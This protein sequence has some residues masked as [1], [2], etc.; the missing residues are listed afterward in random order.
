MLRKPVITLTLLVL[1]SLVVANS[2]IPHD[3]VAAWA[4]E[5]LTS[6]TAES[7]EI[8]FR[9]V[10]DL[11]SEFHTAITTTL[12][13]NRN[14]LPETNRY[15]VSALERRAEWA[16]IVL[17]PTAVIENNWETTPKDD[18]IIDII[19]KRTESGVWEAHLLNQDTL[20]ALQ[21]IVPSSFMDLSRREPAST[22]LFPWTSGQYWRKTQGWHAT[23]AIDFAPV[24]SSNPPI[25][26]AVLAAESGTVT[27]VCNDG[28]Q[29]MLRINHGGVT[30]RY[31]HLA[32]GT[33]PSGII[34]QSVVRGR[35][36]GQIYNATNFSTPCGWGTGPH[37]HF[38]TSD[39]GI[40]IDGHQIG[41]VANAATNTQFLSS[42]VRMD[43][44]GSNSN[45]TVLWDF[46]PGD[47]G[48][49]ASGWEWQ[50]FGYSSWIL[51]PARG[52][53][54]WIVKDDLY[55]A[56]TQYWGVEIRMSSVADIGDNIFWK[57]TNE[58]FYSG[59]KSL[60]LRVIPD[61]A[62]RTITIRTNDHPKWMHYI[63]G[64]R[65]DP[66]YDGRPN[67]VDG[68]TDLI[69]IDWVKL[70]NDP[71]C[72]TVS[73][74]SPAEGSYS[75]GNVEVSATASD[76][77]GGETPSGVNRV[78][79]DVWL[80]GSWNHGGSLSPNPVTSSPYNTTFVVPSGL[81]DQW[82]NIV[83]MVWDNQG[84][85]CIEN[86]AYRGVYI[87][88]TTPT[89][90]TTVD[91]GCTATSNVWQNTCSD[92]NFTWSGSSDSG[93]GIAGYYYYWG[94]SGTADPAT[95]T[96]SAAFD[97]TSIPSGSTYYLRAKTRDNAGNVSSATTLFVLKYDGTAPT[98]PTTVAPGCTASS[99]V[100]QNTCSDANFTWSGAGDADSGVAGYYFYW[101]AS[102]SGDPST[103]TPSA[104]Y[105]PSAIP[106]G[107]TYYLRVKTKDNA[108]N[109]SSPV[110][111][112]VL[113][114]DGAAPTSSASS[115]STVSSGNIPITWTASDPQPGSGV[116][117]T[118]LWYKFGATGSWVNSGMNATGAA[119][120]FSFAPTLGYGTYY[121]ATVCSDV[122]GNLESAPSGQGDTQTTF[123]APTPTPTP[124]ATS[125]STPTPTPTFTPTPTATSTSTPTPTPTFTPTPSATP[126]TPP[127]N[128]PSLS[129]PQNVPAY[130]YQN[131][132]MPIQFTG[133]GNNISSLI[134]SVDFDQTCL[135]FDPTDA[136]GDDVPDAVTFSVPA[137]FSA[138]VMFNANNT[139]GELG[140]LIYDPFLPLAALPNGT[141][142]S[143]QLRAI[144]QPATGVPIVARVG[145]ASEPPASFGTT[146]G[147]SVPGVTSDGSVAI[148][149][150][151]PGDCNADT[152]V[153][154]GDISALVL[155]IFDGDGSNPAAAPGGTF[156][157]NPVGCNAN[158]DASI[159]AGDI[160]CTVLII[161]NGPAACAPPLAPEGAGPQP[162]RGQPPSL[163]LA[164]PL[165]QQDLLTL[166]V[167]FDPGDG[168]I[169]SLVFS[170]AYDPR[171]LQLDPADKDGDGVP[172]VISLNLPPGYTGSA[173]VDHEHG[174]LHIMVADPM[175]PLSA[176]PKG[177]LLSVA[178]DRR[179]D[180]PVHEA[181]ESIIFAKEQLPSFGDTLG[182]SVQ[183]LSGR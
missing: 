39:T 108:G 38:E 154:A 147:A 6:P 180:Q 36:L 78:A 86:R 17:V 42:N 48:W 19:A 68:N 55:Y 96:T 128:A 146:T 144:C 175:A 149:A 99:N 67:T 82:V 113:K 24:S 152:S 111:L 172:D 31:L 183:G 52:G 4:S 5:A 28:T 116:A 59:D 51:D 123:E 41:D 130:P 181:V 114:Y 57:T 117:Q 129:I 33:I 13:T 37:L 178:W 12:N 91:S 22:F 1:I 177:T 173:V 151:R 179:D 89:N 72:P 118:V 169:S 165:V 167:V 9:S 85:E 135:Q 84:N 143:V 100:W 121:F 164:E 75:N 136:D 11:P 45:Q 168:Q 122:A 182:R 7:L 70:L 26:F 166:P 174:R 94:T 155:E 65:I 107:G 148:Q 32:S 158:Q 79:W 74:T 104:G 53:D 8:D 125:T 145:F 153:N 103:W 27:Q 23:N 120:T 43:D 58:P 170:L 138:S 162:Q 176:L 95:W 44:N 137:A 83:A 73:I 156:P 171:R 131:V 30:T 63:S 92:A 115:P 140:F 25:H 87:D 139:A 109:V 124:T 49:S 90:P 71:E 102:S 69:L 97:P 15:T 10:L 157:G 21:E 16:H 54:P 20:P 127:A 29:A 35:Y 64:L 101:G 106:S 161:F 160:S 14:D 81:A 18:E 80:D 98:N 110:T 40:A 62:T 132:V 141:L 159:D 47:A 126:T 93:S 134:F 46:D 2:L 34:N 105:D 112:F 119:G 163:R 88:R 56:T 61:G 133:N 76:G 142:A 66:A 50:G 60:T 150:V 3:S 77:G